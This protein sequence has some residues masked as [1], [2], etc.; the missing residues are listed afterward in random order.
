[1]RYDFERS[2]CEITKFEYKKIELED[3]KLIEYYDIR[4]WNWEKF[5]YD[6]L[7]KY[8]TWVIDKERNS[9]LIGMGGGSFEIPEMFSFVFKD[10]VYIYKFGGGGDRTYI[11]EQLENYNYNLSMIASRYSQISKRNEVT[12]NFAEAMAVQH[13]SSPNLNKFSIIFKNY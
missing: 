2:I 11:S 13:Y 7:L 4:Q 1:M 9:F 3:L 8:G 6:L 5:N 12:D 10:S